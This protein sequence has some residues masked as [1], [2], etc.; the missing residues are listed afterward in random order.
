[1]WITGEGPEDQVLKFTKAG[2]FVMQIGHGGH[3]KTNQDTENFWKPQD[4]SVYPKTNELFV[5]DGNGNKRI[6]VFDAETGKYKRMWG[7]FGNVP[8]TPQPPPRVGRER[9]WDGGRRI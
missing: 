2:K 9:K 8:W 3:K 7:A 4:V 1:V 6:I 5:A